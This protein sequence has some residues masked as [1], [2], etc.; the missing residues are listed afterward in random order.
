MNKAEEKRLAET[1][2][3]ARTVQTFLWGFADGSWGMEEWR[4]MFLK[5][6]KKIEAIDPANP[7][8]IIEL[9]KRLLQNAALSVAL[10]AILDTLGYPAE[11]ANIPSNLPDHAGGAG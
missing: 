7:H 5:R 8:A 6:I 1:I 2:R 9:K 11:G 4:R 10:L 3:A